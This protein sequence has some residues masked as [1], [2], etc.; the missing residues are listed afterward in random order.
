MSIAEVVFKE[1]QTGILNF[2]KDGNKDTND[3]A[4][5]R[6]DLIHGDYQYG[7]D[8]GGALGLYVSPGGDRA[9]RRNR[10]A[11][12][13]LRHALTALIGDIEKVSKQLEIARHHLIW[14]NHGGPPFQLPESVPADV[15]QSLLRGYPELEKPLENLKWSRVRGRKSEGPKP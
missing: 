3:L 8:D 9:K 15:R 11:G 1:D 5:E 2:L 10:F 13:E 6:N 4:E 7:V 12:P 14:R